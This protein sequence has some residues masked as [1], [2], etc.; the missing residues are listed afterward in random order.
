MARISFCEIKDTEVGDCLNLLVSFGD[1]MTTTSSMSIT[2]V[3]SSEMVYA[4]SAITW[5]VAHSAVSNN[6]CFF[7]C[8]FSSFSTDKELKNIDNLWC[9]YS[10][11]KKHQHLQS[12]NPNK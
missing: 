2:L 11:A 9:F 6:R 8:L 12:H 1:A 4:F 7:I 3:V 10:Y 5:L